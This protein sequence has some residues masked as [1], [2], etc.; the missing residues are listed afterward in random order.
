MRNVPESESVQEIQHRKIAK[1]T[2]PCLKRIRQSDLDRF[3]IADY[4]ISASFATKLRTKTTHLDCY[5]PI[6]KKKKKKNVA[7]LI[8]LLTFAAVTRIAVAG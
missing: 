7:V 4:K 6:L 3:G 8:F 2:L 5:S 1:P